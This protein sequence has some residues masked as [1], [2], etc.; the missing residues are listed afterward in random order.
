MKTVLLIIALGFSVSFYSQT[1]VGY[2]LKNSGDK[3]NIYDGSNSSE[4]KAIRG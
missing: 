1:E 2:I 3:I 4:S